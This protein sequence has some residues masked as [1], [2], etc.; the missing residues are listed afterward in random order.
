MVLALSAR[1]PD[2]GRHAQACRCSAPES[3]PR[4][5]AAM[6]AQCVKEHR[7]RAWSP[8][9]ARLEDGVWLVWFWGL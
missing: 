6:Q 1:R 3:M 4:H 5:G 2:R 8:V 7:L 9:E